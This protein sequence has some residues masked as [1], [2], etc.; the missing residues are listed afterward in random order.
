MYFGE[1][2]E[3]SIWR[4]LFWYF[5]D[6]WFWTYSYAYQKNSYSLYF[7][8]ML[9]DSCRILQDFGLDKF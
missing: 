3:K 7:L 5:G 2:G 8:A 4:P 6:I 9:Q 1:I